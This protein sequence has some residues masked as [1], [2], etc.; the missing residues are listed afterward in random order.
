MTVAFFDLDRTLFAVNSGALW[1]RHELD[2]GHIT[3]WQAARAAFWL[4]L[5]S[6]GLFPIERAIGRALDHVRGSPSEALRART[7]AFFNAHLR[8]GYRPG[9]LSALAEHRRRGDLC[10]LL[11]ASSSYMAAT[12][13]ND[14]G[15]DGYLSTEL[16]VDGAGR[17]TGRFKELC[18]GLG[19]LR[20]ARAFAQRVGTRLEDCAFY[21]DSYT[22]LPVLAVVGRPVAVNPDQRL[23]REALR[24]GWEVVDWGEPRVRTLP[25]PPQDPSG[26][27]SSLPAAQ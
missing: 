4:A 7:E 18:F 20:Q 11:T 10:V 15:L 25:S 22:D 17:H 6:L 19:K 3:R 1:V 21:T 27:S 13:S 12:V 23:R 26:S 9:A 2:Q 14:L 16:E 8:A 24:R 5:Y